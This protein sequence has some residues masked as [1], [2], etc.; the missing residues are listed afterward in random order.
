MG[1]PMSTQVTAPTTAKEALD[2]WQDLRNPE[3][4]ASQKDIYAAAECTWQLT[5]TEGLKLE[6]LALDAATA[7]K[8]L[9]D[10]SEYQVMV[11]REIEVSDAERILNG[12]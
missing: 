2:I 11:E 9:S 12:T 8:L 4:G 10:S 5:Q 1:V 6:D 7:W 3:S